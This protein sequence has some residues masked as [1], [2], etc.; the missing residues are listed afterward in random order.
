[1]RALIAAAAIVGVA[2][3]SAGAIA[4]ADD[5]AQCADRNALGDVSVDARLLAVKYYYAGLA[6][7]SSDPTRRACYEAIA[8][9]SDKLPI[10][11]K[12]LE[13][14]ET[15]CLPIEAAVKIAAHDACP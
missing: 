10:A 15:R 7:G 14:I 5:P 6:H 13:L 12:T 3:A 4:S 2:F 11:N 8:S 1:M 9:N